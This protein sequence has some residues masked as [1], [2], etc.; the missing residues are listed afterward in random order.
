MFEF[1]SFAPIGTGRR[2]QKRVSPDEEE[3]EGDD[4]DRVLVGEAVTLVHAHTR[5]RLEVEEGGRVRASASELTSKSKFV[6]EKFGGDSVNAG[7]TIYLRACN[8]SRIDVEGSSVQARFAEHVGLQALTVDKLK[9]GTVCYGDNVYLCSVTGCVL[10]VEGDDVVAK[11][12]KRTEQKAF[13]IERAIDPG[14]AAA[15]QEA[16]ALALQDVAASSSSSAWPQAPGTVS[17]DSPRDEELAARGGAGTSRPRPISA[18]RSFS[19]ADSLI[20]SQNSSAVGGDIGEEVVR[21]VSKEIK[22]VEAR[23]KAL[24]DAQDRLKKALVLEEKKARDEAL[25]AVLE[26]GGSN[27][28]H[29]SA[30]AIEA[31]MDRLVGHMNPVHPL[32]LKAVEQADTA[33]KL[34][35][36][37]E[38]V[39][40]KQPPWVYIG[41]FKV[42]V[43]EDSKVF[44][45]HYDEF[46]WFTLAS[47]CVQFFVYFG[48]LYLDGGPI[49]GPKS[50]MMQSYSVTCEDQRSEVVRL[51]GYQFVHASPGHVAGNVIAQLGV[52]LPFEMFHGT[53][54]IALLYTVGVITG[55]VTCGAFDPSTTVVGSS[56]GLYTMMGARLANIAINWR[57][58]RGKD[59]PCLMNLNCR[60]T[61]NFLFILYDT[62]N[63]YFNYSSG[64]SYYAHAGGWICGLLFGSA[65]LKNLKDERWEQTF[66]NICTV[67]FLAYFFGCLLWYAF[68]GPYFGVV[69]WLQGDAEE[70]IYG[71]IPEA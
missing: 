7:E 68:A 48:S 64:T 36:Y 13:T 19:G 61:F 51:W 3:N 58:M 12:G 33:V 35:L 62:L 25:V 46:P 32:D 1:P 14:S 9:K 4:I 41:P 63:F 56:G 55:A 6:L 47:C 8:G 59:C 26:E 11:A 24:E 21:S 66:I 38:S 16:A 5:K 20:A 27:D 23:Q 30:E 67:I 28:G 49:A 50:F 54:R 70:C 60:L 39:R 45:E 42:P 43:A 10:E 57:S 52:M 37:G 69:D 2:S 53:S 15:V 17:G 44:N 31:A 22:G 40:K 18:T 34:E 29:V 65:V 71:P